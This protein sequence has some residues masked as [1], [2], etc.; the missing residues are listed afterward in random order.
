[1]NFNKEINR[2]G[3]NSL[4][5]DF[6]REKN[7]PED[8]FPMWV[9]DMDFKC[10]KEVIKEMNKRI[11]H[12]IF[13]YSQSNQE[14]F[15][16]V[17]SWYK[18]NF[19]VILKEEWLIKTPG[20]VF[21][22]ATAVKVLTKEKDYVL[23]NNPV[24]YPFSEVVIDNNRKVISSNL[25]LENGKYHI[26]FDDMEKK[27][28]KYKIKLYLL[29]S[30]HNPV[31]RV[32]KKEELDKII[33]ICKRN[34]VFI[35]SDEIHSDFIWNGKHR[36]LLKY[37]DYLDNMIVCTAP[38]KTFNLAG[39]Q[40]SNIFIPN[41]K[42]RDDF[43]NEIWKT[44]YSL[45]NT[46]G[47]VAC[48]AAYDSGY[49]WLENLRKYLKDNIDFVDNFLKERLPK[50][51]LI[52]PEGTYLLWLDFRELKLTDE[53]IN[54]IMLNDAKLWLDSGAMFG[55]TGKGFQRLNIAL[56]RKKLKWALEQMER[57]FRNDE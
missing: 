32:W 54:K 39:L 55:K 30:P 53:E 7:K 52:Y 1:M 42:V 4:K 41:K 13:G 46:M 18:K 16:S 35:V 37:K 56:P 3:T 40:V 6:K 22:L 47:I 10:P 28:K 45:I 11:K 21:A 26:N 9:A 14:Y 12:G 49:S 15:K 33:E 8:V 27:I 50:V 34:K 25:V 19:N 31:G 51:K 20:V 17:Y 38:S 29:C 5:Y 44:G 43:Q 36:C 57:A 2:Y 48:K 23:I 24:Y